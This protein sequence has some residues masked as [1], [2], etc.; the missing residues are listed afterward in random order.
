MWDFMRWP[1][2]SRPVGKTLECLSTMNN[3]LYGLY[4]CY[5]WVHKSWQHSFFWKKKLPPPPKKKTNNAKYQSQ[6]LLL[7]PNHMFPSKNRWVFGFSG[8]MAPWTQWW[9]RSPKKV[10]VSFLLGLLGSHADLDLQLETI[11][12]RPLESLE[13]WRVGGLEGWRKSDV[14]SGDLPFGVVA[15]GKK[16]LYKL[17]E[18]A[19]VKGGKTIHQL[20][21]LTFLLISK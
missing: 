8:T 6:E 17:K 11:N 19:R 14:F 9:K 12:L 13:G 20:R 2:C 15:V 18:S 21:D 4:A 1:H 7:L 5:C 3:R 16:N 10:G